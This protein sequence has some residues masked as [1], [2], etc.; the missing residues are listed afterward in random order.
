MDLFSVFKSLA[1]PTKGEVQ[2]FTVAQIDTT[3]YRVG[4]DALGWPVLLVSTI[5]GQNIH[6]ISLEHLEVQYLVNCRIT[7]G[8][9]VEEGIF[10]V[11]RC[12]N[13]DEELVRYFFSLIDP[14]IRSL[15]PTPTLQEISGAIDH[16][17]ELFRALTQPPIKS[18]SGLWAELLL[19]ANAKNPATLLTAW[20]SN[21]EE[22]Y[23]FNSNSQRLEVKS[24]SQRIRIHH[25]SLE[26]LIP[27][28]GCKVIIASLFVESSGGG[29]SLSELI[30]EI[31]GVLINNPELEEKLDRV[32]G[33]TL[34]NA[35]HQSMNYRFDR[36]LAEESILF[37]STDSVPKISG[38][39]PVEIS[40]VHFRVDLGRCNPIS[41][42]ELMMAEGIFKVL[43]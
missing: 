42:E 23:D 29:L 15:G 22:K 17:V 28:A 8:K 30:Q 9:K 24:T 38:Q 25:F 34:G 21:P 36:Q 37:L 2:T 12:T 27:P 16:L 1:V 35:I 11:I 32:V 31:K 3:S 20:H 18:V 7:I 5:S 39:L 26:Q 43:V 41:K 13:A 14:I 19:I 6:Q 40:D 33:R 4:K 10:T